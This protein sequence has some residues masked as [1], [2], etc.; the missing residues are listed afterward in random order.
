MKSYKSA[1][2]YIS[3][4]LLTVSLIINY[5]F[6]RPLYLLGADLIIKMQKY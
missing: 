4:I 6:N 1:A 3:L 5:Y 2:L